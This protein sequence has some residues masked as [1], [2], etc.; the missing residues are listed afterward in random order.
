[1]TA[2]D[3]FWTWSTLSMKACLARNSFHWPNR[4]VGKQGSQFAT[5]I[6]KSDMMQ[7]LGRKIFEGTITQCPIKFGQHTHD[8]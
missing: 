8:H 6:T 5:N 1:M 3:L 4:R 2:G 7:I